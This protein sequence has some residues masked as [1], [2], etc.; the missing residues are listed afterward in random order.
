MKFANQNSEGFFNFLITEF[1]N[2]SENY[3][4]TQRIHKFYLGSVNKIH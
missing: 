2:I 3:I 4:I 1:Q